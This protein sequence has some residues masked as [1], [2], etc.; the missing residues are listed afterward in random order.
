ML[1]L[2]VNRA[3][4]NSTAFIKME[5]EKS[6]FGWNFSSTFTPRIN[7]RMLKKQETKVGLGIFYFSTLLSH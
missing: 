2:H 7:Q 3:A 6:I 1:V 4:K 5:I